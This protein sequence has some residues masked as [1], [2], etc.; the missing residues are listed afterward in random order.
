M[1]PYFPPRHAHGDLTSLAP[2]VH[3]I[4]HFHFLNVLSFPGHLDF[5]DAVFPA[6]HPLLSLSP[7]T[8]NLSQHQGLFKQVSSSHRVPK[9]LEFQLQ[10]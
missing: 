8:F 10:Q 9:V 7:S 2:H 3:P 1:V 6:S 5:Q 4:G